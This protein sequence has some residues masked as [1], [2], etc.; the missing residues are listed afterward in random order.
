MKKK[1]INTRILK[2]N[3]TLGSMTIPALVIGFLFSYLPMFGIVL[4]FKNYK[5]T[6]GIWGSDW[7]DPI[8]KNFEFFITSSDAGRVI[9]NTLCM[10]FLFIFAGLFFS[11]SFALL[12]FEVKKAIHVKVYQTFAILPSFLSWV[13][14]SYIVYALLDPDKGI[15]NQMIRRFGG[16]NISWYTEPGYWP[17]ILLLV[18]TWH[19]VGLSCIV[20]Y[21]A[22]MG[23][24]S[25]L[26]EA[27]EV[28]GA[29]KLQRVVHISVPHLIPIMVMMTILDIGKI[30]RADFGLFYNVPRNVGRLYPVTD[31]MDTY[32]YR[33]LMQVGDVG[34]SSAAAFIQSVVC[35]ITILI[36]NAIVKKIQPDYTLF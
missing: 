36:T 34:M 23:I 21:A 8:F 17:V 31:V 24:D 1:R 5:V 33:T 4:A 29:S 30:F 25:E 11:V 16:E 32:V 7:A 9:R 28:D 14:V 26:F 20:Y 35:T 3:L 18:K 10:N 12:L 22:L 19:G 13:A 6:K 15:I 27:A 2:E